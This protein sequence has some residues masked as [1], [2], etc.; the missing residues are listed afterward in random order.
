MAH[1]VAFMALALHW[2]WNSR[3]TFLRSSGGGSAATSM[4]LTAG[5]RGVLGSTLHGRKLAILGL[6]KIS[7]QTAGLQAL[8]GERAGAAWE[9]PVSWRS[10]AVWAGSLTGGVGQDEP[11]AALRRIVLPWAEHAALRHQWIRLKAAG[12]GGAGVRGG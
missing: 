10:H 12:V 1:S 8:A 6:C 3:N 4:S 11:P 7:A 2:A 5:R 9:G